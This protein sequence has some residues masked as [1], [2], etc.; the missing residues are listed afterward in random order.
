MK[1]TTTVASTNLRL[2]ILGDH[3]NTEAHHEHSQV[4][5]VIHQFLVLS[6]QLV[7]PKDIG[8]VM[9]MGSPM[10]PPAY[11]KDNRTSNDQC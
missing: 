11:I 2:G 5:L 3:G 4:D 10:L 1:P 8:E 7:Q 6:L 9:T